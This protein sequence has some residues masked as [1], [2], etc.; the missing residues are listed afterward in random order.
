MKKP[1]L[2]FSP[3][4]GSV[5]VATRYHFED[6]GKFLVADRKFDVTDQ[7]RSCCKQDSAFRRNTTRRNT[8][9]VQNAQA[10]IDALNVP[11]RRPAKEPA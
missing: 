9:F 2:P 11:H 1:I 6:D 3:L 4:T 5:Y 8:R 7:F 10:L